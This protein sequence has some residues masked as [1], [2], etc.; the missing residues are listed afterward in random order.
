MVTGGS[1][2]IGSSVVRNFLQVEGHDVLNLDKLTYATNPDNLADV[3]NHPRYHFL[4]ADIGNSDLLATAFRD[5]SPDAVLHLAAESHVDRSIDQPA[6]FILTNIVGSYKLLEAALAY[7]ETLPGERAQRFRFIHV[8]TDEVFGSLADDAH[9]FGLDTPYDPRSPY[10]ASKAASD[11]I[12]RAWQHT[13]GLPVIV[14]NCSNNYGPYQFPEKFIPLLII[15][16]LQGRKLPLYGNGS[17]IR[18]WLFVEDHCKALQLVLEKGKPGA[19]YM[20]GGE[21]E[22]SNLDTAMFICEILDRIKPISGNGSYADLIEFVEDRP[23]HDHRYAIDISESRSDIGWSPATG[24]RDGLEK[25]VGWY[26]ENQGWWQNIMDRGSHTERQ[27]LSRM[28]TN[29]GA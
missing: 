9:P 7:Y 11:H 21:A 1:G 6:D 25:T 5:F 10:S 23:G 20:F 4:R 8:S 13:Y 16:C 17:N 27:G 14:T 2:F 28:R 19:T 15:N 24:F 12:A 29:L 26:L 22:H 3:S 18:D